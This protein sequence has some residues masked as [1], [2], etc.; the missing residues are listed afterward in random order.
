MHTSTGIAVRRRILVGVAVTCV[1]MLAFTGA[2]IHTN[3][4][5]IDRGA[6]T[7]VRDVAQ[8]L[9]YGASFITDGPQAL[10]SFVAGLDDLY[11]RDLVIVD[12]NKKGIADAEGEELGLIYSHDLDNEVGQTLRDG[13]L[14]TFVEKNERHPEGINQM[15]VPLFSSGHTAGV[16]VGALILE[17]TGIRQSLL[18]ASIWQIY[19]LAVAGV[20][21]T[22][23]VGVLGFWLAGTVSAAAERIEHLA[24]HDKLTDLPNRS[25]FARRL[26]RA[27][28]DAK[29]RQRRFAVLF[30]DLDRFKNINDTLGHQA[31]DTLLQEVSTRLRACL[32]GRDMVARLGGDEF[33]VLI[34]SAGDKEHLAAIA[35]KLL[36][37]IAQPFHMNGQ[38]FR[39]TA[40]L[41]IGVYPDDGYDERVLMKNADIAMYQAKEDGKNSF[42]FYSA[43]LDQHSVERLAFESSFRHA[44]DEQQFEVHYQPKVDCVTGSITGVEALL[45]WEHADLGHV[46]PVKFIP[47]AE[48]TG[49]IVP[50]G[51]WV[52]KTAC[53]QQVAWV[54]Q[55]LAPIRMAVNLSPR[56][57]S[58]EHLRED[59]LSILSETGMDPTH[60]ELEIT[61]SMLMRN[62]DKAT[63]VLTAFAAK[64]IRLSVDDFGTGYSSL[65]NLKQFPIDTIKVDR[66]FVRDL[67]SNK[68]DQAIAEAIIAMGRTLSMTVI[69]EGVETSEQA[70]F[71]REHGCDEFQGFYF[72]KAIPAVGI[73]EMLEAQGSADLNKG[74]LLER[75]FTLPALT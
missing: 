54:R 4:A 20:L 2:V 48:E 52:L 34:Q 38:E 74:A 37:A 15:V 41:G 49:L 18:D 29:L 75:S 36:V 5:G 62:V 25:M 51:R 68:G 59:V 19:S 9:A 3:L 30:L 27:L 61:E 16:P 7:E 8:A 71:L 39:V 58:D 44:V 47:V 22:M 23:A 66:S 63:E 53:A 40:S 10:Q 43:A 56:Q 35:K 73:G 57:F 55:G 32:G 45:R 1:T 67:P 69:A 12:L 33:V 31:G 65:S 11:K 17:Y 72:S 70:D 6:K 46:S 60:L 24:Y 13:Q 26:D 14:R 64:G 28:N 21:C 42:A 50:L